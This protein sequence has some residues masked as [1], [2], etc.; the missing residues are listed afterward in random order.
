MII[1]IYSQIPSAK[2]MLILSPLAIVNLF[3]VYITIVMIYREQFRKINLQKPIATKVH[4]YRLLL[5][6]SILVIIGILIL[7]ILGIMPIALVTFA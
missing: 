6:K 7:L 3:I 5:I 1:E 4:I 2:F